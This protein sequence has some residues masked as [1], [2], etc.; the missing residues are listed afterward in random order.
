V[1]VVAKNARA[2]P[3]KRARKNGLELLRKDAD[4]VLRRKSKALTNLL[5]EKALKGDLNTVKVLLGL[6]EKKKQEREQEL[7][8]VKEDPMMKLVKRL[9][10][11]PHWEWEGNGPLKTE[12]ELRAEKLAD[13]AQW[14]EDME[15]DAKERNGRWVLRPGED[16]EG[17]GSGE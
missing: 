15:R 9:K 10:S 6:A 4:N 13:E 11:E 17:N 2:K 12:E 3:V 7:T 14:Q 1:L 16:G 5:C 8:P